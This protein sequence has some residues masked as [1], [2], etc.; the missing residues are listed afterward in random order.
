[1]QPL[2]VLNLAASMQKLLKASCCRLLTKEGTPV[3]QL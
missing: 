2:M 1:M 3:R